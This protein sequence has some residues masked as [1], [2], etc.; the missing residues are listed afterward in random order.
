MTVDWK[1]PAY[2]PART[3]AETV[4]AHFHGVPDARAVERIVDAAFWASLRQ[5]E[6]RSPKISLAY[7]PPPPAGAGPALQ[8]ERVLPLD[9][10]TLTRLA[11]AVERPG[12]H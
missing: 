5:E 4:E 1:R 3:V 6:G 8:L 10:A 12:I 7:L 11:P 2:P 9:P